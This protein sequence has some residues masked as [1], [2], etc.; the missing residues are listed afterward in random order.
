MA[1][2]DAYNGFKTI[3]FCSISTGIYGFPLDRASLLALEAIMN[4]IE[5]HPDTDL[6]TAV[7]A[8]YT[9]AEYDAYL[10]SQ[11]HIEEVGLP[12]SW[13]TEDD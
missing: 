3:G 1:H 9:D 6:E 5:A 7:I 13:P 8:L 12:L 4:W 11:K 2:H 10:A